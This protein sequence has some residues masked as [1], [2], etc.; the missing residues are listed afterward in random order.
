[1]TKTTNLIKIVYKEQIIQIFNKA[2]K[3]ELSASIA[4]KTMAEA[5]TDQPLSEELAAHGTEEYEHFNSLIAYAHN[6]SV[7]TSL[8][9]GLDESVVKGTP[10]ERQQVIEFTQNLEK[11][12]IADYKAGAL[13]ARKNDDIE[14]EEFF[15]DLMKSEQSHFDDLAIWTGKN[16]QLQESIVARLK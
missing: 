8:I 15:I 9:F 6:H 13:L 16:R 14:L 10:V 4:Y 7:E 3:D 5:V 1:L 12:A 11:I 2:L